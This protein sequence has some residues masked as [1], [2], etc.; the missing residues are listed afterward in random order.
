VLFGAVTLRA[1]AA[2]VTCHISLIQIIDSDSLRV[3]SLAMPFGE[4]EQLVSRHAFHAMGSG[5]R[6]R[7]PYRTPASHRR[8]SPRFC[9][10]CRVRPG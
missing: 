8:F 2:F 3:K 9:A 6:P 1:I 5:I 7:F 4:K 10:R